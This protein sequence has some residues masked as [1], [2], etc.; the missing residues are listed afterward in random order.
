MPNSSHRTRQQRLCPW[1]PRSF[2]K[3]EHLARHVRTHTKE[4]PFICTEC[5]KS[6]SR[7]DSLL[8]HIRSH[9]P[10]ESISPRGANASSSDT[11]NVD[12]QSPAQSSHNRAGL[13]NPALDV[14]A[15]RS[16]EKAPSLDGGPSTIPIQH[17]P[18]HSSFAEILTEHRSPS[19]TS[20]S[21]AYP[22]TWPTTASGPP[23]QPTPEQQQIS[24]AGTSM[25]GSHPSSDWVFN[26]IPETP[27]WLAQEDFDLD[28][29]NSAVMMSANQLLLPGVVDPLLPI[30]GLTDQQHA[31]SLAR[32]MPL[33]IEDAVQREWFT[34]TGSSKSGYIT[35]D[36][37]SEQPEVDETYRA[38]LAVKLQHHIPVPPLPS[39]EFLNMC[40]Q[41]YFTQFHPLFPVIHAPTFRP[42]GNS[43]LLLLSICSIGSLI[44]GLSQ[45]KAHGVKI[46]ET[47]NKAILSSWETI[48]SQKGAA[49]TPMIQAALIGQTFALLSGRQKDLFIAQTF[50]GTLL[51]WAR[52]YK[53]FRSSRASDGISPEQ[54]RLD[55]Q[56][57]WRKWVQAEEKN[58]IA[59]ALHVHDIEIAEL[60][61][62]D[63]YLRHSVPKRPSLADDELWAAPTAEDWARLMMAR[64]YVTN[65]P[66]APGSNNT[67]ILK[68][69]PMPRLHAYIELEGIA[70]SIIESNSSRNDSSPG[71]QEQPLDHLVA[72]LINFYTQHLKP[73]TQTHSPDPFCL[74]ALWHSTFISACTSIDTLELAIGK[75]GARHATSEPVIGYVRGWA[76]S[77]NGQ[78]AALHAALTLGYLRQMPLATEPAIHVPRVIFRAAIV[79]YCYTKYQSRSDPDQPQQHQLTA[80]MM[81]FPEFREMGS[82][83]H[84]VFFEAVGLRSGMVESSTFSGLVDLLERLGHWG[85]S[86]RLAGILRLLLPDGDEEER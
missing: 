5:N 22:S 60:F 40:I 54:I 53:M 33:P 10:G 26:V 11:M 3:E 38:N 39:T 86:T 78:R 44:V 46:F 74:L 84:R 32:D 67:P 18:G 49:A 41:T 4:K 21:E 50:H 62:T 75:E 6:F 81:Q 55:P 36:I 43:S 57:A 1:C 37:G 72:T 9:K 70:A 7:H 16:F 48:L 34:Y 30:D 83:C 47:L 23:L 35:P 61:V 42:S 68:P 28:A 71:I 51:A 73:H 52:R 19:G 14:G 79:W 8:R 82:S 31:H 2:T 29:L 77:P 25:A 13:R 20:L 12:I 17:H 27:A 58:R 66:Q 45:A 63:P 85:I 56:G 80:R 15:S 64:Q 24:E 65:S 76:D 69:T 59:A